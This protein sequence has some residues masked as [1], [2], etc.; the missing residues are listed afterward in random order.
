MGDH[1]ITQLGDPTSDQDATNKRY[2]DSA[3]ANIPTPTPTPLS[4]IVGTFTPADGVD[5]YTSAVYQY[6]NVCYIDITLNTGTSHILGTISGISLPVGHI[7][8]GFG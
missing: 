7:V 4:T 2:V 5:I 8:N 1:K 6:G 3:I